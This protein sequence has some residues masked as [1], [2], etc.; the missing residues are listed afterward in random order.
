[1]E[2]LVKHR[3]PGNV[4]ELK[5]YIERAVILS[6]KATLCLEDFPKFLPSGHPA[7]DHFPGK[8]PI[9][10]LFEDK[11]SL[12]QVEKEMIQTTLSQ[13]DGNKSLTAQHL[14]ISRKT[15]YKKLADYAIEV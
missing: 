8:T 6:K 15:L 14:G 2:V 3:W 9:V 7:S 5:N 13:Y 4:R 12:Q 11:Y 1:M 10:S